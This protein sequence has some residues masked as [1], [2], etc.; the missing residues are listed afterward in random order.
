MPP[1]KYVDTITK[2]NS[3]GGA[4]ELTVLA[5]HYNTEITSIDVESGRID[6]Y[7]PPSHDSGIIPTST[8]TR[9]ILIYSG[10]HYD[11]VSLAP[12]ADAPGEWHQTIFEIVR[13]RNHRTWEFLL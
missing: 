6:H 8:K 13:H 1:H 2:P 12:S 10:I 3:W 7:T 9:C 11:A 5:A 4:I